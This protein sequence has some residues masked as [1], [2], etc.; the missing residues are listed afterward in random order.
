MLSKYAYCAKFSGEI[1][2]GY[3]L[4]IADEEVDCIALSGEDVNHPTPRAAID[5]AI[6]FSKGGK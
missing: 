1:S 3:Q 6:I 2:T 4:I 5:A